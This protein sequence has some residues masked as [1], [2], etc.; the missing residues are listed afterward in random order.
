MNVR[1]VK[2]W[3]IVLAI[4]LGSCAPA[5]TVS[6]PRRPPRGSGADAGSDAENDTGS[7]GAGTDST[8]CSTIHPGAS[9][10]RRLTRT[11][12]DNT[13]RDL[14][15]DT[16]QPARSFPT[17]EIALGFDNSATARGVTDALIEHYMLAAEGL[18]M[19]ASARADLLPCDPAV[20][21]EASCADV[22][23]RSFGPNAY[24]RPLDADEIRELQTSFDDGRRTGT[25]Q[26]G[27]RFVIER[28]LQSPSF[29]YRVELGEAGVPASL[30]AK[31]TGW[32]RASR[33]SYFLWQTMPDRS[34]F[35]AAAAGELA[36]KEQVLAEARRMLGDPKARPTLAKFADQWLLLDNIDSVVKDTVQFPEFTRALPALLKEETRRF[37]ADVVWDRGGGLTM[38]LTAPYTFVTRETAP[39]Y[40]V[41]PPP[42]ADFVRVD[43]D[44]SQRSGIMTQ[45]AFL[46]FAAKPNQ[47]SPVRRGLFVRTNLMCDPPSS[48]PPEINVTVP[49]PQPGQTGRERFAA[50]TANA[51]CA[52]CHRDMDPIGFGFEQYDAIGRFRDV[53]AQRPID[54][55]GEVMGS[56][57]GKF[58]GAVE[59]ARKLSESQEVRQCLGKQWFRFAFGREESPDDDCA[60]AGLYGAVSNDGASIQSLVL[61][62]TQTDTFLYRRPYAAPAM[63]N[64]P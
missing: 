50:H 19:R 12:Y 32:E 16:S 58:V 15:G 62:I 43:L 23:I 47:T 52:G 25:F 51:A 5:D 37:V 48:P 4:A 34:L 8:S 41:A 54:A 59:L 40:G 24:R 11:E 42:G 9:P 36:T 55:S 38:L 53:D 28:V 60:L 21:G 57:I 39:L 27:V 35:A 18:A 20:A 56:P 33:L 10:L 31:L 61:A 26:S 17:E 6:P 45:L 49:E 2:A 22:F 7:D 13:V 64:L 46:N 29:L 63:E 1:R 14:L 30:P 44:K 3:P